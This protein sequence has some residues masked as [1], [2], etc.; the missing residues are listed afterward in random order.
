MESLLNGE[1]YYFTEY[2]GTNNM[3]NKIYLTFRATYHAEPW[4]NNMLSLSKIHYIDRKRPETYT[5]VMPM[6]N[7]SKIETLCDF[8]NFLPKDVLSIIDNY[9]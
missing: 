9:L 1:R 7:I 2:V 8:A 4:C 3:G 6:K 5:T